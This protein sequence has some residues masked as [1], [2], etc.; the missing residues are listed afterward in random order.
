M[1]GG[2]LR[3]FEPPGSLIP[4]SLVCCASIEELELGTK[5]VTVS[6]VKCLDF[7]KEGQRRRV[8]RH[9]KR[10]PTGP[11][12]PSA[13]LYDQLLTQLHVP[14]CCGKVFQC[15]RA[16]G[17]SGMHGPCVPTFRLR[18]LKLCPSFPVALSSWTL[19]LSPYLFDR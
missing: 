4:P 18:K 17:P 6:Y 8:C 19:G 5:A 15:H 7:F 16:I 12:Y 11:V 10:L 1:Q 14:Q 9:V 3:G 13:L 2:T